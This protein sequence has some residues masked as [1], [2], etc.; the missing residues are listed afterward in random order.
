MG[1]RL[2]KPRRVAGLRER[3]R[4]E[5]HFIPALVRSVPFSSKMIP[6]GLILAGVA[7]IFDLIGD[8]EVRE[9]EFAKS[10]DTRK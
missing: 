2:A 10:G 4:A 1:E 9:Q 5:V 6:L 7:G 3:L 8:N